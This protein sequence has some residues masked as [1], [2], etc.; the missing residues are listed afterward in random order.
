[1]NLTFLHSVHKGWGKT[2]TTK[3]KHSQTSTSLSQCLL[4]GLSLT[5]ND[6]SDTIMMGSTRNFITQSRTSQNAYLSVTIVKTNRILFKTTVHELKKKLKHKKKLLFGQA[7]YSTEKT[8]PWKQTGGPGSRW[9]L[10]VRGQAPWTWRYFD[11]YNWIL[12]IVCF[13]CF[14]A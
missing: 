4:L 1:M 13:I 2:T 10:G 3:R 7:W 9:R 6:E 14:I 12:S 8:F 5:W 11:I